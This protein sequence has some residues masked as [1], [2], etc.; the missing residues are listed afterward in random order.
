MAPVYKIAIIQLQPK[1]VAVEDNFTRAS[2]FIHQAAAQ[3]AHLAVLPEYHLTSWCPDHPKFV[4]ACA[5]SAAYL[6][7]YQ[8]L[9]R[10]LGINIVPG[11]FC[12]VYP[13]PATPTDGDRE[14]RNMAYWIAAGTGEVVAHYQKKNLWHCERPHLTASAAHDV[15]K[16]FDTPLLWPADPET[17]SQPRPIR[18]GMLICWDLIFPE[19]FRALVRDGAEL[20]VIPSFWICDGTEL[21]EA[22]KRMNAESERVFLRSVLVTRA[23]EN[24]CVV[25]FCNTGGLSQVAAPVYGVV[26]GGQGAAVNEEVMEVVEVDFEGGR[27]LEGEYKVRKDL[28]GK[29]WHYGYELKE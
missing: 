11:T 29:G 12:E 28:A 1:D 23:F 3:G 22:R 6:P 17:D 14:I 5:E 10:R 19:A 24:E 25:V 2:A 27:V 21:S 26:G 20:I 9:A 7:R 15:H 8:A 16:A 18:A 4:A 13:P